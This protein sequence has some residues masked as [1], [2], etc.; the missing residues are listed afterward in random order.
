MQA[1][2]ERAI[3]TYQKN[4]AILI[5]L[6]SR[7]LYYNITGRDQHLS[8]TFQRTELWNAVYHRDWR[9]Y[10]FSRLLGNPWQQQNTGNSLQKEDTYRETTWPVI[11]QPYFAQR[12][13]QQ[14][15]DKTS[16]TSLW[17][18]WQPIR[19]NQ[20]PGTR[21]KNNY[22]P[23]F[24][25]LNTYK[26]TEPNETT[27]NPTPVTT[28]TIPYIKCTSET[29][30]RILQPY[31]IRVAHKPITTLRHILTNVKD[32]DQCLCLWPMSIATCTL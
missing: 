12:Y 18:S 15:I 11:I 2:E 29:I 32:K 14:N 10:S 1:I 21:E 30:A 25:K 31:D 9:K 28:A 26:N 19:W 4:T 7:H 24:I 3:A 16:A 20:T 8:R 23:D 22:K 5:T 17:L 13:N 6:R 27:N